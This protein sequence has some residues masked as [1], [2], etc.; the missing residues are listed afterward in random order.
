MSRVTPHPPTLESVDKFLGTGLDLVQ[1]RDCDIDDVGA[2]TSVYPLNKARGEA[3]GLEGD[4]D[5]IFYQQIE[6]AFR[7][8]FYAQPFLLPRSQGGPPGPTNSTITVDYQLTWP[9]QGELLERAV[10]I[11]EL[12]KPYMINRRQ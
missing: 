11:G 8:A 6:P 3:I 1:R 5:R 12:K 2:E 4:V 9:G 10:M 7:S